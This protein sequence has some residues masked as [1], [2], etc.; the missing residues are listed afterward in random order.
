MRAILPALYLGAA[1]AAAGCVPAA[2]RADA[3]TADFGVAGAA[4]PLEMP[5]VGAH[6]L[7][8][9]SPTVLELTLITTK[10]PEGRGARWDFADEQN[11]P[12]L[13]E[14]KAFHVVINGARADV[15]A[16]GFKRRALY[17]PLARRDLR[18]GSY[19]YLTLSRPVAEG[20]RVEVRSSDEAIVAPGERFAAR[21][22][23]M[24][25]SPA[26]HVNQV[27]YG[28]DWPKKATVGFYLGSLGEMEI[29]EGR[30]FHV[31]PARSNGKAVLSGRLR[32]RED[33]GFT[34]ATPP[35]Q[36][37]Y[38]ADFSALRT[39][40]EYRLLVPG[41][42]AS[43]PFFIHNGVA[44]AFARTYALGIYHQRCGGA[45]ALP[46]TRFPHAPCHIAPAEVPTKEFRRVNQV[47]AGESSNY[48]G[49][50]RHT[51]PQLKDV[52][53]SRYPFVNR[54]PVDVSGG[55]HDAGDYS[56]YVI[57][58]AQF[59]HHLV[60]AADAFPGAVDLDN[61]GLPESGDGKSDLLQLAKWEADFLAKMQ[62]AD[63]GFYFLVYPRD[64]SYENDVL[65]DRGDPQVV[66]PKTS[67]VTAAA[68]AALA[69]TASSPPFRKAFPEAAA[70]YREK[71][72]KGWAFL[73]KAIETHGR[74]GAY[75]K[76]THYGDTFGH[77]DELAWAATE[78][79]LLDGDEKAHRMLLDAFDPASPETKRWTWVRLFEGYGC[80]IRSY[81]FAAR[82][83]RIATEKLNPAHREKCLT[84]I[85]LGAQDQARFAAGCAYN[86]SFPDVT[87][88][89]RTAGWY[90]P[91]DAA[92][93]I[94]V[95][96]QLEPLQGFL[97]ALIGN[98]GY[99]GGA[100]PNNVTFL[101][102]LGWRRQREIVHHYAMNDRHVLPPSG[103][104]LGS[105]QAGF[106]F[107][108]PYKKEL[109]E[110]TFP[111][112]GAEDNAFPL[113]DRWGDS[114]NVTTEFV[115]VNQAKGLAAL[116]YL[117]ARS[118]LKNQPWRAAKS[119]K[120]V[121]VPASAKAGAK[122]TVRLDVAGMDT[123]DARIVWEAKGEE[124]RFGERFT[125]TPRPG[126]NWIAAEAQWPNGRRAFAVLE[127]VAKAQ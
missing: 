18:I 73:Q 112:D 50:P 48:K 40:G 113:Y 49:N 110:I 120:I 34:Y 84:E 77:D 46:F 42:G 80:A 15:A 7:R 71:A 91:M 62:D 30:V 59:I 54:G 92:F 24:R 126:A 109:G 65:P 1:L 111:P 118:P 11:R 98:L 2:A 108:V 19:L 101:T 16:V 33:T 8:I 81:A 6:G 44:A 70:R 5:G 22:E 67:A 37:V 20:A 39:P 13:P 78:M 21:A 115:I 72:R 86:T 83:G 43:Y 94:A 89:F 55:H 125:C 57:N 28:P 56:K 32:R 88:R 123:R 122:V 53:S 74:D 76:I 38:E 10:P 60:F 41:L 117:M 107:L 63:G 47:L 121:G 51:A 116:A 58:S 79:F 14:P 4:N 124:P 61:L 99:E 93:D 95:G 82:T 45:N 87:K 85:R 105:I 23:R 29:G 12:R 31:V 97:D 103:L 25:Y 102:G 90:F 127:F 114:F 104:P 64:R 9:L 3:P 27:G 52:D 66:F 100:N 96:A 36:R 106:M 75:Q 26:V 69:Q 68:V 17:A 35:Y 119:A